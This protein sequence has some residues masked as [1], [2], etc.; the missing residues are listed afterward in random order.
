MLKRSVSERCTAIGGVL[1]S[2]RRMA[3]LNAC[4][5]ADCRGIAPPSRIESLCRAHQSVRK[6]RS[7]PGAA[8]AK[9]AALPARTKVQRT[10]PSVESTGEPV[11]TP[12]V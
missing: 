3:G 1:P 6:S 11:A 5:F 7:L 2:A 10:T 12:R 8:S 9:G 4:R